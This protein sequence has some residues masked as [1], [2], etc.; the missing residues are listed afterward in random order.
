MHGYSPYHHKVYGANVG[1]HAIQVPTHTPH[2][3]NDGPGQM[4]V[5]RVTCGRL[6]NM[7]RWSGGKIRERMFSLL[8][9]SIKLPTGR[10][11]DNGRYKNRH[12]S[13]ETA[14]AVREV[15]G[16]QDMSTTCG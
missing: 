14:N 10:L 3:D 12:R 11:R 7:R 4:R 2:G 1:S 6:M 8:S 13:L 16:V 5:R 9:G 15:Q